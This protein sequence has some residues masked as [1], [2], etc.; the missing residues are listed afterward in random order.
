MWRRRRRLPPVAG[1]RRRW[2]EEHHWRGCR[3]R[4]SLPHVACDHPQSAAAGLP[5]SLP[6]SKQ[7][8]W[9][10][11]GDRKRGPVQHFLASG[12]SARCSF[13]MR[14]TCSVRVSTGEGICRGPAGAKVPLKSP[15]R[16]PLGLFTSPGREDSQATMVSA[17]GSPCSRQPC[18]S[19]AGCRLRRQGCKR[20]AVGG[21]LGVDGHAS[22]GAWHMARRSSDGG[23]L[24]TPS[25][26]GA[27]HG[28]P[29]GI[30]VASGASWRVEGTAS[31]R[32]GAIMGIEG[33][34]S[35]GRPG[36]LPHQQRASE[37]LT[38]SGGCC[39]AG[40]GV[41]H[42]PAQP[43]GGA[44]E[45]QAQAAPPGCLPQLILHGCQVPGLLHH[46]SVSYYAGAS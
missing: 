38:R 16:A 45:A 27:P 13:S 46:V 11:A 43:S 28:V 24:P 36:R 29:R 15:L 37:A 14:R 1:C 34:R 41:R 32:G 3:R 22:S 30:G 7:R 20:T 9:H 4:A 26:P 10:V 31:G 6:S 2:R 39:G 23:L 12:G 18:C 40:A 19:G 5:A 33:R 35:G 42:R 21:A 8:T 25:G 17:L 44:G